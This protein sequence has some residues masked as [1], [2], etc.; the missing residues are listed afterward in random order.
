MLTIDEARKIGIHACIEKLGKDLV[1][2]YKSTSTASWGVTQGAVRC[3]VGVDTRKRVQHL[4]VLDSVS[5]W[6]KCA[7]CKVSLKTREVFDLKSWDEVSSYEA[8]PR[9]ETPNKIPEE[10][11]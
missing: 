7:E 11:V 5:K 9:A 3:F 1:E 10:K 6:Y 2:Q 4:L 8:T